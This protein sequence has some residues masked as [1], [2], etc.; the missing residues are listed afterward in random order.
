MARNRRRSAPTDQRRRWLIYGLIALG[1]IAIVAFLGYAVWAASRPTRVLGESVPI[2]GAEHIPEGQS[3]VDYNSDPPTSGQHYDTPVEA[4]FYDEAP[5]DEQLVHNL[6][7][8]HVVIYYNCSDLSEA[9]CDQLK[10]N[11]RQA[12]DDAGVVQLTGTPKLVAVPRPSMENLITYTSWGRLYRADDFD[13]EEFQ[14]FV[15]QNRNRAPEP[16]AP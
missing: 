10:E 12:M 4:G 3:A 2:A 11:I 15:E 14:L 7:H 16:Q 9:D 6:E 13:P 5:V 8:G 1:A